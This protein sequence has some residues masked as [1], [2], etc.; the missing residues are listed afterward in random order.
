MSLAGS[1]IIS[2]GILGGI[3]SSK[4]NLH[5]TLTYIIYLLHPAILLISFA[6]TFYPVNTIYIPLHI[7]LH[8]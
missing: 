1:C 7:Y 3:L 6:I 4:T 2:I 5:Y 8:L